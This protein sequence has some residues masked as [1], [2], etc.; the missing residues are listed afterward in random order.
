MSAKN[1]IFNNLGLKVTALFLALLVW[2]MIAGKERSYS[3][4]TMEVTVEY[5]GVAPNI[6]IRSVNPDKVRVKVKGTSKELDKIRAEDFE[7]RVDLTRI[8]ESTRLNIFT[9]D[10]LQYPETIKIASIHPRM[11]EITAAE[12]I[13]R[14]VSV[15]VRYKGRM[16]PGIKLVE[17]RL[18]PEK[19]K[20]FGYKS[21]MVTINTVEGTEMVDLSEIKESKVIK[22]PLRKEKEIIKFEDFDR[23]EVHITVE[24][25]NKSSKKN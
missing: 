18:V 5:F 23:V 10:V 1:F 2:A 22:I 24:N 12:L 13:T 11:I 21:Q 19:V 6:D 4:K 3:E 20:I 16:K 14:E 7:I 15:R 9:E 8:T 25:L 17:R